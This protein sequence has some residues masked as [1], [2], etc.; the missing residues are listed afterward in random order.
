MARTKKGQQATEATEQ[1]VEQTSDEQQAVEAKAEAKA[2]REKRE[3]VEPARFAQ[4]LTDLGLSRK[5]A[6]SAIGRSLS[7]ISE[8]TKSQGG[9]MAI[10]E[11]FKR[12]CEEYV[13][14]HPRAT[15]G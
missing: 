15:E 12:S 4:V 9:S 8:L 5:E 13:A 6:A 11:S 7:R 14:K 3:H 2:P 1:P 10:F